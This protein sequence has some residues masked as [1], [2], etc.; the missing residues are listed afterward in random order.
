MPQ[1]PHTNLLL[2]ELITP[3]SSIFILRSTGSILLRVPSTKLPSTN[4]GVCSTVPHLWD[5]LP[6]HLRASESLDSFKVELKP[7]CIQNGLWLLIKHN[8]IAISATLDEKCITNKMYCYSLLKFLLILSCVANYSSLWSHVCEC[9]WHIM[10][11]FSFAIWKFV[12]GFSFSFFLPIQKSL[13][14][15]ISKQNNANLWLNLSLFSQR[16][17]FL[18]AYVAL[19]AIMNYCLAKKNKYKWLFGMNLQAPIIN[20]RIKN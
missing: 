19:E 14:I 16:H 2:Q 11:D 1:Y 15:H 7:F 17:A 13:L 5:S 12:L 18:F 8:K 3:Q 4:W 6:I 20:S 9:C 10:H